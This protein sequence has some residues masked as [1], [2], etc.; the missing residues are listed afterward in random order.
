MAKE[1]QDEISRANEALQALQSLVPASG[2]KNLSQV[3]E[4]MGELISEDYTPYLLG[5]AALH[6]LFRCERCGR[7]CIDNLNVA[8]SI[9]DCRRIS[10]HL[11]MGLKKFLIDYTEPHV[12]SREEVGGARM[13]KKA[14]ECYCPF[15][16]S[17]IPGCSI[18]EAKPQVCRAAYYLAKM[19]LVLCEEKKSFSDF[20][21]CPG[22]V[23][24]RARLDEV[25]ERLREDQ[26]LRRDAEEMA[27]LSSS[28][29]S[30]FGLLLRLKGIEIY[31][32]IEK[33][34]P[35]A[36]KLGLK[37]MPESR[38]LMPAA[39]VYAAIICKPKSTENAMP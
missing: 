2:L 33:A 37:R 5:N 28:E 27:R 20:P 30:L 24:L 38:E 29:H 13:I 4:I 23:G 32:G 12:L 17:S 21:Q 14:E 8:V 7:C 39:L 16:D 9:D 15:Y 1:S 31:F 10:K 22:D 34:Q 26:S 18:H 35:L 36:R 19:N 3:E 6:I 25:R 11:G